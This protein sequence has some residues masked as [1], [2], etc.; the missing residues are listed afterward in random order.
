VAVEAMLLP[1]GTR[2]ASLWVGRDARSRTIRYA[3]W[4]PPADK[5]FSPKADLLP[6]A[7]ESPEIGAL[8]VPGLAIAAAVKCLLPVA[9]AGVLGKGLLAAVV[10]QMLI[11]QDVQIESVQPGA[12]L[13]LIVDTSGDPTAWSSTLDALCGEGT[14]LLFVPPWSTPGDFNFY[15]YLHR[16]SLRVVARRW[17][18]LPLVSEWVDRDSLARIISSILKRGH[19]LCPLNLG[20]SE[21]NEE[22]WQLFHWKTHEQTQR[23]V[24][25]DG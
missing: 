8:L 1:P 13:A 25:N 9:R 24:T 5:L 14:L 22:V 18:R 19:W 2:D 11:S 12:A 4:G 20:I 10:E 6:L 7:G 21:T 16:H 3:G 17:H 15:P 23:P